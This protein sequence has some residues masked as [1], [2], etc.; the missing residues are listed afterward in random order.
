MLTMAGVS[1]SRTLP[2]QQRE[3][4]NAEAGRGDANQKTMDG[5]NAL[6]EPAVMERGGD[7]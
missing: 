1:R 6:C 7:T 2:V 5:H 4:V 3:G